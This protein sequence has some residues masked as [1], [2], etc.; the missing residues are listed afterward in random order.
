MKHALLTMT[1]ASLALACG[2]ETTL[3][4][5]DNFVAVDEHNLRGYEARGVSADGMVVAVRLEDNAEN[6]T[7]AFWTEAIERQLASRNYTLA[8]T[9]NV[10]SDAGLDGTLMTL[11][12]DRGGRPY[13]YLVAVF[14]KTSLIDDGEVLIA[15]AGGETIAAEPRLADLRAALLSAR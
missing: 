2:C 3:D 1:I 6:G 11:N 4:L 14:V 9:E 13:T 10:T 7:L 5:P 8:K 12:T 15:E